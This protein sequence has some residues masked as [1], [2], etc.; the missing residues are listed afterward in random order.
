MKQ[1]QV[2][3]QIT[4][5][6][7]YNKLLHTITA[8]FHKAK[9]TRNRKMWNHEFGKLVDLHQKIY[10]EGAMRN[11]IISVFVQFLKHTEDNEFVF[12]C[13]NKALAE[14]QKIFTY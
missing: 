11:K 1:L 5:I 7:T 2:S 10:E 8:E 12:P 13:K 4:H 6:L 14:L 9:P 3:N